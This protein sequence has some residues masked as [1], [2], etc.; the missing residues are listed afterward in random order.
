VL[1]GTGMYAV[2]EIM[3][4]KMSTVEEF[5]GAVPGVAIVPWFFAGSLFPIAAMPIGLTWFARVLP[6]THT[7]AV[8]RYGLLG[9]NA[10]GLH[11]I[12]GMENATAMAWLSLGAVA[13]FAAVLGSL[14]V[15][16]FSRAATATVS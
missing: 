13:V 5:V 16:V 9:H 2:A 4:N 1:M 11:D 15:R 3:A 10:Q 8:M 6:L 7:L 12:W 14:A